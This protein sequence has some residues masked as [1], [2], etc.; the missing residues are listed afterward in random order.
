VNDSPDPNRVG[1]YSWAVRTGG[2]LTRKE[3]ARAFAQIAVL[4]VYALRGFAL[5][6]ADAIT[7]AANPGM[8]PAV[9]GMGAYVA[10]GAMVDGGLRLW[11]LSRENVER[12]LAK[13]PRGKGFKRE[14]AGLIRAEAHA[15]PGS[16]FALYMRCGMPLLILGAP[17]PDR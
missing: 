1:T 15:V 10:V 17:L 11:D 12:V 3:R 14:L 5:P 8:D 6:L 13:H 16:R 9:D 4:N 7:L 2:R